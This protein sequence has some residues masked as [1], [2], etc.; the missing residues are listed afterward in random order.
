MSF[1]SFTILLYKQFF[2]EKNYCVL[3]VYVCGG[4]VVTIFCAFCCCHCRCTILY[5]LHCIAHQHA[6]TSADWTF[7]VEREWQNLL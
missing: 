5:I 6:A 4:C 7:R 3:Y 1:V 2:K